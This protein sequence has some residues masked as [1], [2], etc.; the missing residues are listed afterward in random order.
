MPS[1][2]SRELLAHFQAG[3]STAAKRIFD[4]YVER[5]IA[6]AAA[7]L[8]PSLRRRVDPED[9]VQSAY[10][11]FFVHAQDGEYALRRAGD[12]W[13]LLASITL[14]KLHG[15]VERHTAGRRDFRREREPTQSAHDDSVPLQDPAAV[16]PSPAEV[17]ALV[18]QLAL[19]VQR[20]GDDCRLALQ[21]RLAGESIEQI[22]KQLDRSPR[23]DSPPARPN[24][25]RVGARTLATTRSRTC[26]SSDFANRPGRAAILRLRPRSSRR[27]RRHGKGLSRAAKEP[28]RAASP[29]RP[30]ANG[31]KPTPSPSNVSWRRPASFP[32]CVIRASLA[33]TASANSP[34]AATSSP[35]I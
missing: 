30:C 13:R 29:S 28:I 22:A 33:F 14:H 1:A 19:F 3:D 4:R 23:T 24:P 8:A 34:A 31:D 16:E 10:R 9:V 15:Q 21:H 26:Q 32:N 7:R 18:E 2:D 11:S 17:I 5:L 20:L 27:R 6:L 35:S 25:R 12:L